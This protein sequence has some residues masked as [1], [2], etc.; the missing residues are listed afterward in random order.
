MPDDTGGP[1]LP[2]LCVD[3]NP[4]CKDWAQ[5][6]ECD[7]NPSFMLE[8]CKRACGLCEDQQQ[9]QQ[10]PP[11]SDTA[12]SLADDWKGVAIGVA[13]V[14]ATIV[15]LLLSRRR[16]APSYGFGSG[17]RAVQ[18]KVFVSADHARL[19]PGNSVAPGPQYE[20]KSAV[21]AQVAS[22]CG[23]APQ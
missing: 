7:K 1:P 22:N 8:S 5:A 13:V 12:A 15:W 4:A 17:T 6:G 2:G 18:E 14:A 16:S 23:S 19:T 3:A 10:Q 21:G 11:P 9:Q 20:V